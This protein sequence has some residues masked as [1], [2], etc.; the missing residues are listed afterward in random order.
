MDLQY[1]SRAALLDSEM[2]PMALNTAQASSTAAVIRLLIIK[3]F[4]NDGM[5]IIFRMKARKISK[6][7][8]DIFRAVSSL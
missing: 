3:Y 1:R 2:Y 7:G 5:I 8:D 4:L 6:I